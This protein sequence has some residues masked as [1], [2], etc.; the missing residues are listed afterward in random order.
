MTAEAQAALQ[1]YTSAVRAL[2]NDVLDP[3][4]EQASREEDQTEQQARSR[5]RTAGA[6]SR[7]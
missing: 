5:P 3:L 7:S 6:S 1:R 4:G 2:D